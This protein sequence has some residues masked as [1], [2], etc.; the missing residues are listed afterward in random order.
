MAKVGGSSAASFSAKDAINV[1]IGMV[2]QHFMLVEPLTVTENLV[3]GAEPRLGPSIDYRTA[4]A[5]ELI[6]R[7]GFELDP[8]SKIEEL[9]VRLQQQ[10]E[11]RQQTKRQFGGYGTEVAA[12]GSGDASETQLLGDGDHCAIDKT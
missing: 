11:L 12:I 3:L 10:V 1:G 6:Q 4:K 9:S 5:R 7:F 2:H 8:D